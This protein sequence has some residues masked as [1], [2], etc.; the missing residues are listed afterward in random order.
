MLLYCHELT[1]IKPSLTYN[2]L[3]RLEKTFFE[4]VCEQKV[5]KMIHSHVD[6]KCKEHNYRVV[7]ILV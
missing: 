6:L 4:K 3:S 1:M 7:I 5:S 2:I